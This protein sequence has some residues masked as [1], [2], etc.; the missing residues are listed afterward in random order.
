MITMLSPSPYAEESHSTD[1]LSASFVV[2]SIYN[3]ATTFAQVVA[4]APHSCSHCESRLKLLR[5]VLPQQNL[6]LCSFR[7]LLQG[8]SPS[9]RKVGGDYPSFILLLWLN[10][11]EACFIPVWAFALRADSRSSLRFRHPFMSAT[12]TLEGSQSC[13]RHIITSF[14][15]KPI[16]EERVYHLSKIGDET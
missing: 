15:A 5:Q 12:L 8:M 10:G 4:Y 2:R 6:H 16:R 14:E 3:L 13:L 1:L 9:A 11:S 7:F